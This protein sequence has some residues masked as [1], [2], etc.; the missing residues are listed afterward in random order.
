AYTDGEPWDANGRF[1]WFR[2][3][4]SQLTDLGLG[5]A[6]RT[7]YDAQEGDRYYAYL[8]VNQTEC[9][10]N[11][12]TGTDTLTVHF[13][14]MPPAFNVEQQYSYG[15]LA[16]SIDTAAIE[17]SMDEDRSLFEYSIDSG[18]TFQ[19]SPIFSP[20]D[21]GDY[22]AAVRYTGGTCVRF[23]DVL[24]H[25]HIAHDSLPRLTPAPDADYCIG[26]TMAA[27]KTRATV[28]GAIV[29]WYAEDSCET[30]LGE[31]DSLDI[32][33]MELGVGL[34]TFY[35]RQE[36]TNCKGLSVGT[37]VNVVGRDTAGVIYTF[38]A[39][40]LRPCLTESV[41]LYFLPDIEAGFNFNGTVTLTMTP[42]IGGVLS[43]ANAYTQAYTP[44]IHRVPDTLS[45][46]MNY[47]TVVVTAA[48]NYTT[49]CEDEAR[50]AYATDTLTLMTFGPLAGHVITAEQLILRNETPDT[51]RGTIAEGERPDYQ[52]GW[53]EY[54]AD[55][56]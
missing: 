46:P 29:R 19:A 2:I 48:Y 24:L 14:P 5:N 56:A 35:A 49:L 23:S 18:L 50:T 17:I 33:A 43:P 52:Y 9:L 25:I 44:D 3:R 12:T 53:I 32:N 16:C 47:D 4:E 7:V 30:L 31:G 34:H 6:T 8:E 20:V 37:L 15:L 36:M 10:L 11:H 39:S 42:L 51:L 55:P 28:A 27:L 1:R 13:M 41:D 38:E 54:T 22:Y 45:V 26:D 21:E 40:D